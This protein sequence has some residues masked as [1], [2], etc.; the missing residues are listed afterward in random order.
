M[1]DYILTGAISEGHRQ[2]DQT[3]KPTISIALRLA[4]VY[5]ENASKEKDPIIALVLYHD[6]EVSLSLAK[7]ASKNAGNQSLRARI[8]TMYVELGNLLY[9]SGHR[10]EAKT[11]YK[12][13]EKL[14]LQV[15]EPGQGVP[16]QRPGSSVNT[17]TMNNVCRDIATIPSHIFPW[18]VY[19][20]V[21]EFK[22][23]EA[24]ERPINT[25]Q[26]AGCLSLLLNFHSSGDVLDPAAQKWLRSIEIDTDEQDRLKVMAA[27][28]IRAFKR[29]ELKDAKAVA[30][31]VC[32]APV[33]DRDSFR[34]LLNSFYTGIEQAG[35]LEYHQLEGLAQLIQ[36][37]SQDYLDADDLVRILGLLSNRLRETHQ[38]S[39]NHVYQLTLT[40][41]HI[42]DAMAD[43]K[44]KDL[45]RVNLHEPLSSYLSLLKDSWDPH[46]V[47]QAAYAYQALLCVPDD[48]RLWQATMR[49]TR[50]VVR[51][52]AGLVSAVKGLDLNKFI[53]GLGDIQ[54]G[55]AGASEAVRLVKKAYDGTVSLAQSGQRF[56]ECLKE[57][58]SF[59]RKRAWYTSL[60]G[61][62]ML[63]RDGELATFKQLV[64]E[65]PCRRDP[66]FQWGVCHRL[67]EIASNP[68]W[69]PDNRRSAIAFLGEIYRNDEAWGQ[70]VSIKQWIVDILMQLASTS[71]QGPQIHAAA[72]ELL[73]QELEADPVVEKK[74]LYRGCREKGPMLHPF[75]AA[76]PELGSPSLLDRVQNR[77]DVECNL[78]LLRKQRTKEHNNSLYIPPQAKANLQASDD[79]RFPLMENVMDFLASN[80]KVFLVLGDSGSGKSTFNRELENEI[81]RTYKKK[82]GRIPIHINLPAI[83]KPEHD[84]IAKQLRKEEFTEPQIRELKMH[85][86]FILICDGYD[87]SQQTHNL[88]TSNRLNQTG[89][90]DAQMVIGCRS[91]Y[92][93]ADYRDRFQPWDRN[94]TSDSTLFQEAVLT[95]FSY[96]Q[97]QAYIKQF[98]SIHQP[99]WQTEDYK[100]ALELIPSLKE[101]IK[102]PFLMVLSLDVLPRMVDPGQQLS[103]T[104]VTRVSLYDQFVRQW[105]ERGKKRISEKALSP[106]TRAVFE[107]LCDEGFTL[108]GVDFLKKFAVAIYK[109]QDGQPVVE[110]SRFKDGGTWKDEFFTRKDKQLLREVCPL[111]RNGSQHR[112]I[113][114]SILEY[115]LALAIFDPHGV[116]TN[117]EQLTVNNRRASVSS[118]WSFELRGTSGVA[119]ATSEQEPDIDSP[120]VWRDFV[121]DASL[122]HFLQ[123]RVQQ[124][125]EFEKQLL[126]YIEHSKR[127]KKWRTAAA[128]AITILV[129]AG[130]RFIS[131]DLREI[132][133]PGADLSY[134]VFHGSNLQNSDLR[135]VNL[136]GAWMQE[137]D[138]S[139]A[140]MAG[141]QFGELPLLQKA[142]GARICVYSPAGDEFAIALNN[143]NIDIYT[144]S[145]WECIGTLSKHEGTVWSIAYSPT[146]RQIASG[147][148]DMVVRLWD[149]D[150]RACCR[151][152][153]GHDSD[154]MSVAFSPRGE[155]IASASKDKTIRIWDTS[156]GDNIRTLTKHT[157][158][159]YCV[160]F[161][162]DGSQ[163]ASSGD[164]CTV[165][166]WNPSTGDCV[167]ILAG[168]SDNIDCVVYSPRGS[169][170]ASAS[171]DKTVRLW[172]VENGSCL[173]ILT[174]NTDGVNW[175][176]Y[177]PRGG[178]IA[179]G[180]YDGMV[181]L[182]DEETGGCIQTITGHNRSIL[183]VVFS[184]KGNQLA[185]SSWD[186]TIALYGS[187]T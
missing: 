12:K 36:G 77:P 73:L 92:L 176:T 182:W 63:I 114:R 103:A 4:K 59:E 52:V 122:L 148:E 28:V 159:V 17:P 90:W 71:G 86:K 64:C 161:S 20:S 69:N 67:G 25:P 151:L 150:T 39:P 8:A 19:P 139:G 141:V 152:L 179:T 128:N 124:E 85:R 96:D 21:T 149:L 100:Q 110:Y 174:G 1:D 142:G 5:L 136:H 35:L 41:S 9:H 22:L 158:E 105:L 131:T 153:S 2:A 133:I 82:T 169:Q 79:L 154:V 10:T 57:G 72:A 78:R 157:G 140:H 88:Y 164:D 98:V 121:K 107:S 51:G 65:I 146:S 45:H 46:L 180:C 44:V 132:Q 68:V 3:R 177:S 108:N 135:K 106:Q 181:R 81:W 18:N 97:V 187:G 7:K 15:K 130:V 101:L 87:E 29:D 61:A 168:H 40:V 185:S 171:D 147:G 127:D 99:L 48:E 138:L 143:G 104:R 16:P 23:L 58:L 54:Q 91:E 170:V 116:K 24:D 50:K 26:L 175:V 89:E 34:D 13:A 93:G 75:R 134:G 94:H 111:K 47:F 56:K 38:Q 66:A 119:P 74:A 53:D 80:R 129:R 137:A 184:P 6:I 183:S 76:L 27:D 163:I 11:S 30:E 123:E 172:D 95:P 102:N 117:V 42:L 43:I 113:H 115:G 83:D 156:T 49:R 125:P 155:I 37:A 126:G 118:I 55:F 109:E 186:E 162:P 14:G 70:N 166:L 112:F 178:H 84:M 32:L 160:A 167:H 144:T 33:L 62:D 120:L 31:V 60:R 145:D 165:R 173:R